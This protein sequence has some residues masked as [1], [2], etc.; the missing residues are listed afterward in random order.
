MEPSVISI[1][2]LI[3][4][5][6]PIPNPIATVR[7]PSAELTPL[8]HRCLLF[9]GGVGGHKD[10]YQDIV[11]MEDH[12]PLTSQDG[13]I[14]RNPPERCPRPLYSQDCP[15][16]NVLENHQVENQNHIKVEV[17]DEPEEETD[18]W[19]DQ[20][21]GVID[22]NPP[23]RCPRPLYSQDCPEGNV[24]EKHQVEDQINIKVEVKDEP[25][26]ET[27]FWADH[28]C[29]REVKEEIP[30]GVTPDGVIDRNPPERCPRPLYSQDCPE[31]NVLENHKIENQNYIKVE[32]KD[33]PEEETDFGADQ[34]YGVID[35]NPPERCP[36]PLYSQD[37]P[38]GN[39]PENNQGEDLMDIKAE[40]K[41]EPEE[42]T[43][44]GAGQQYG[45]IDRNPPERCPRP[46]YSQD[47]PEGNVPEKHQVEDLMYI[48]VEVKDEPEEET[49]IWSNHKC[50]REVKEEIPG[51][52]TP[53]GVIDRNPP[54]RCP[55]PLY[56]QDCPEGNV[57]EKDQGE[58]LMDIKVE[59]K[60]EAE[61]ET[62]F[63]ADQQYGVID[64]NPLERCPRPLYS[65]DCPEGNVP[66]N[67]Q[68]EDQ[69][70]IKDEVKDEPEEETDCWSDQQCMREGKE[71]I[72]GG[73]TPD[74]VIDRNPPERCPRPLYSQ[75]CPDG[76]VPEKHQV[77]DLMDIKAEIK[78]EPEE[79]TDF[80]ADHPC[81]REVK[82]EIPG[83]VTPE[84]PSKNSEGNFMLSLNDKGEDEDMMERSSGEDLLTPNVHPDLSYNNPPDH[85]EPSPDQPHIV[86]T[87][88]DQKHGKGLYCEECGKEFTRRSDLVRHRKSHIGK[89]QYV[90]SE[91]G[92][93]CKC[94]SDLIIHERIHTGE[95]PY[96]CSE[97]G[98]PYNCKSAL[99]IHKRSHTGEKPYSCSECGKCFKSKQELVIHERIHTGEKPYSCSECGK[100]YN[101]KSALIIHKRIHTGEKPYSCSECGKCFKSKQEL[102][103]HERIHTGEKPYSCSECGKCFAQ[104]YFLVL[105]ERSHTG[106]KP[107]SCSECGKCFTGKSNLVKHERSHTGEKPYSCSECD[108]CF[109]NKSDLVIHERIHT[110]EKP[111]SCSE[112]GKCFTGKSNLVKHERSHTGEKPYSCSECDKCFRS[113]SDLVIHERIHTGE[114][115]YSCS[116]C[117]K[118]FTN[119]SSLVKHER[120]HTGEKLCSCPC[121]VHVKNFFHVII[122]HEIAPVDP[123]ETGSTNRLKAPPPDNPSLFPVPL[124]SIEVL[125]PGPDA[126]DRIGVDQAK[127]W[128]FYGLTPNP[129]VNMLYEENGDLPD[130]V[131]ALQQSWKFKIAYAFPPIPLIIRTLQKIRMEKSKVIFIAPRW[132]KRGWY[133]LVQQLS[134]DHP[135]P[136]PVR[137]DLLLQGRQFF[138]DLA[139]LQL[140]AWLL[141]G[142]DRGLSI[143]TLNVQK[144]A[145]GCFFDTSIADHKWIKRFF[146]AVARL[147]PKISNLS[148]PWD[149]NIVLTSL[150]R[151]PFEP[152]SDS[153]I[154]F[155]TW[156]S[157]FL[158]AFTTARRVSEIQAFSI[159]EPYPTVLEDRIILK[160]NPAFLP[161][162]VTN[163][164]R[165][166][167]IIL[168]TFCNSPKSRKEEMFHSLDM[169]RTIL[170]LQQTKDWRKDLKLLLPDGGDVVQRFLTVVSGLPVAPVLVCGD[171]NQVL[172][173]SKDKFWGSRAP[174]PS[175]PTGLAKL[176]MEVGLFDLWRL[177]NHSI[178]QFSCYSTTHGT[179]SRIDLAVGDGDMASLVSGVEYLA[180]GLSDHSPIRLRIDLT[181]SAGGVRPLWRLNPFWLQLLTTA[182][183]V[184]VELRDY[185]ARNDGSA[186]VSVV[187]DSLKAFLCGLFIRDIIVPKSF[188]RERGEKLRLSVTE[189]EARY[190]LDP[191]SRTKDVW[192]RAQGAYTK[193]LEET[194]EHKRFFTKQRYF[195]CGES[196]G[197]LLASIARAQQGVTYIGCLRDSRGREVVADEDILGVM[198]DF[199]KDTY[200]TKVS[201]TGGALADYVSRASLPSLSLEQ[202]DRLDSPISLEELELALKDAANEK[203]PGPDGLP[204]ERPTARLRV[205]GRLSPSFELQMGT[206]QGCPLSPLLFAL[207]I[208]PLACILRASPDL[209][210]FRYGSIDERVELHANDVI[211][212]GKNQCELL[213]C[214]RRNKRGT[215]QS[216]PI[217][218]TCLLL[219]LSPAHSCHMTILTGPSSTFSSIL[220]GSAPSCTGH[221]IV[222][223]SQV[224]HL[225]HP[226][227]TEQVLVDIW[228]QGEYMR[229]RMDKDRNE[230]TKRILHFT[231]EILHL[232]TGEDYTI[233][234]KTWG[235]CVAP[236]SHLHESGGRS[237]ARGPITEP[238][239]H[240]LIHEEKI[241]ELIHRITELLTG[242]VPIRCQDVAVYFS[243][244]EWEYVE[245]HKDLYQDI[246]MMED[247]RPLTSQE[248]PSK[249]SE[250]NFMLS[251]ND[252]GEDE[253]MMER[254]SGED[255]LTPNVH[256]DL[257]YNNP[258]D[259]EE[260]SPDQPHIVTTRT[261]QE[262]GKGL[263]CEECG[264]EFK[265]KTALV[266]HRKSHT[267]KKQYVC[268]ECG[269]SCKYQS[270]LIIHERIHTGEKSYSC[271]ECG[272]CFT[273]KANLIKH[274]RS[275]TGEK[276][277]SCLE[278]KKCFKSKSHLLQHERSH[279]GEKSYSC[280]ECAKCF[281]YK[282]HLGRHERTHTGEKPY[283]CSECAKCFRHKSHLVQHERTH[284]GE[285]PH[286]CAECG[287]CF[288]SKT[289]LVVHER[290]HTGETP[291]SCSE[292]GK[293]F[294]SKTVLVVHERIHTGE[295]PYSCSECG[296]CFL[297]KTHLSRHE[298]IHTGEKPYSC[299][300]CGKC[301]KSKTGLVVH[302][303]IHTGEKPY[304]C[305]ECGKCF[306][307][308]SELV[309]HE[310]NHTG[311]KPYSCPECG[312]C[313]TNKSKLCRHERSHTG[314]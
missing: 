233:V 187:W 11:M 296:K 254:S 95:K 137:E 259:H 60:D 232:L 135:Y 94:Q 87:R 109:N 304:S 314:D 107:Y 188:T 153:S 9:S 234:K 1:R 184:G 83:G 299:S 189:A 99:I 252:K 266:S 31:G 295:K 114:K 311:E 129:P 73:V 285:K 67:H 123:K 310:R 199:D 301:F 56:S 160:L 49:D 210:G 111:Y 74:G 66:E 103:I 84:N 46:L 4:V 37:C 164:H 217:L 255:L 91:C 200:S 69:I 126:G 29:M 175:R 145:L 223:S 140:T 2:V 239:P 253:D 278:C 110:G 168:P 149:L 92:K 115:P 294:K 191:T 45:V 108:K 263:Y 144:A 33:E 27:D 216:P 241:L 113:K 170:Y 289:G 271:S 180:R 22:R 28:Q 16:G 186:S 81:M 155:L 15:E 282:S 231:L 290:F 274:E 206:R 26:E 105:H 139:N 18:F 148:A 298:K 54:E 181:G 154:K 293:C 36:R 53:D 198:V 214:D 61:E 221:M 38:E 12:R 42:E 32:V 78:D 151:E 195:E 141:N 240:S 128:S 89:K 77:E 134:I 169:R 55:R 309:I 269:K 157:V 213:H 147:K 133:T 209:I 50:M 272:K 262:H 119:K 80:W 196:T 182:E 174:T 163:F 136:L 202:R 307:S 194:A 219:L 143:S 43:D 308:K 19:A 283:S 224:L 121:H 212:P 98:K 14:D 177:H 257:S 51:G 225:Q 247:H 172:D 70:N 150:T 156:K 117:R 100:P 203:A 58:D 242:E 178:K 102:V 5:L 63:W 245:G 243:M 197:K 10:L 305:S 25:E 250:G 287:K 47:C 284:T 208:E 267:R 246:V 75:D 20:Q 97:C 218:V 64:R 215:T 7:S 237:R 23:E 279:T 204:S 277:Y 220:L 248:N 127:W 258:P 228:R 116:Q 59:I 130:G 273:S 193:Y 166:Q 227:D 205:N 288:K 167:D 162:V 41:D 312:K 306:K 171:F 244:E 106:V 201:C 297:C 229:R 93:H 118:C 302:E 235:E 256:P 72:P 62:D 90:C 122:T 270:D 8:G 39:V 222:T 265:G 161:K 207:A 291:Y 79:E 86:T 68:V 264:R 85:E 190:V 238:P 104:K 71:E 165:S 138:K 251:L 17:K 13:V 280:S 101:C 286:S 82:E 158:T 249:N 179:L 226:V 303:R 125:P 21:Y 35:R 146:G 65:Q 142:L 260:P 124:G 57:P 112:C 6:A 120:S 173:A 30:G 211:I 76:N 292:C 276:P 300:E 230:M 131:D 261:E 159:E 268:S 52:V 152:L 185:I 44:F 96:S 3:P 24:P 88:T 281:I 192:L 236:S 313:F 176:L 48:K 40:V 275:H 183:I 34:Q 132:L